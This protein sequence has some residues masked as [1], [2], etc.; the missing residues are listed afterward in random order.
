MATDAKSSP[1]RLRRLQH[2]ARLRM[3]PNGNHIT[4]RPLTPL[5][6]VALGAALAS[7]ACG[8]EPPT[9]ERVE[10]TPVDVSIEALPG[11]VQAISLLGDTLRVP[12][13]APEVNQE[14]LDRWEEAKADYDANP[15][16]PEALIW[17]GR[18]TA[19]L[20]D[21][22]EAIR[23]FSEGIE[24]HPDD[25]RMYRHR[26]HRYISTRQFARAVADLSRAAALIQGSED[27]VEPDGIPNARNIPTSTLQSNIWY[28]L[29]LAHYVLGDFESALEAYREGLAVSNN[30][31]MLVATSHWLYMTLRRLGR[32]DEAAA[33]LT[34]INAQMDVIENDGYHQL[35]L[36]YKGERD[37]N[38][39][40]DPAEDTTSGAAVGYGVANW[41]FY[42]GRES[43]AHQLLERMVDSGQWAAFGFIAAEADL[44]R[45]LASV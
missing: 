15:D 16:D 34:P 38:D 33:V 45:I 18:R 3:T 39:L 43:E 14:R 41:H 5:L 4:V 27:E 9:T 28:H 36:L 25:A 17:Y 44:Y 32:E 29:G 11:D 37:A 2:M 42:N 26:G 6:L 20:G 7:G 13:A 31:D 21:Y 10:R 40:W 1:A 24:R 23:I 30:P 35:L 12:A 22:R 19:Y 8:G